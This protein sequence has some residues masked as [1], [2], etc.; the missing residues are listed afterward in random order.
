MSSPSDPAPEP[1]APSPVPEG[2][3]TVIP[4]LVVPDGEGLIEF[5]EK[6]FGATLNSRTDTPSGRVM[7]AEISLGGS[8]IML[9]ESNEEWP[10]TR[11]MIHLYLPDVDGVY[12]RALEAG[13]TSLR[14][15]ETM[16]YGDRSG[17]VED[18]SGTQWWIA[19][20][21]EEVSAEEMERRQREGWT[22]EEER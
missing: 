3:P 16:F 5:L 22:P 14:E 8:R 10:P 4:Y 18:A 21:V 13:A 20:R 19:T 2:Y 1:T 6:A 11:A 7:H 17:G 12:R 9:G 15:P